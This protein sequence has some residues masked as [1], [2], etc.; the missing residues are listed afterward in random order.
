MFVNEAW[1]SYENYI[2]GMKASKPDA[3]PVSSGPPQTPRKKKTSGMRILS[4]RGRRTIEVQSSLKR[5]MN[6]ITKMMKL[7]IVS[8]KKVSLLTSYVVFCG[9]NISTE[10]K[11]TVTRCNFS[12]NLQRNSTLK[13]C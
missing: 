11:G 8:E 4:G 5:C 3:P 6:S 10:I 13:R 1:K 9:L 7:P 12:C 2:S